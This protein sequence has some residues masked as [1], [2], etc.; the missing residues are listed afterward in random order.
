MLE[1]FFFQADVIKTADIENFTHTLIAQQR[2][3]ELHKGVKPFLFQH[4]AADGFDFVRR[5][6]VHGRQGDAMDHGCRNVLRERRELEA[7]IFELVAA[8]EFVI[9]QPAV[10]RVA[11]EGEF[12]MRGGV[13]HVVDELLHRRL[14]NAV[15][16]IAHAHVEDEGFPGAGRGE[17][18]DGFQ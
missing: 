18:E 17:W 10:Q 9:A 6:A 1:G 16:V 8:K 11:I 2:R 15:E 3:V 14:F 4:V 5:A 13:H 7:D 12:R